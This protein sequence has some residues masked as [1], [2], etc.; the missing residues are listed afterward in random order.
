MKILLTGATGYIGGSVAAKLLETGH[1]VIGLVRSSEAA[2]KVQQQGI[3][4]LIG[5]L[6]DYQVLIDAAHHVDA[7]INTADSDHPFVVT[8]LLSALVGSNK[9]FIHT[10]GS[11]LVGDKAAG[12]L[13]QRIFHEDIAFAPLTEKAGRVAIDQRILTSAH[14]GIRSVVLC[15]SLI[16]GQGHGLKKNSIQI[17]WLIELAKT[18]GVACH[19]GKG[20]NIWSHI[21]IDDVVKLY[22]LA[23][24][25][26][27]PGSFFFVENGEASM[28]SVAEAISRMLGMNGQ[29]CSITIDEAIKAWGPEAAH[30]AFGSNSRVRATKARKLLGWNPTGRALFEEIEQGYYCL[31]QPA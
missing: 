2:A 24:Q 10:S 28:K 17:P 20:E 30:F 12:E 19:I 1:Q 25:H 15:H 26:A 22:L 23:M 27:S 16:Y 8:T 18:R 9:L 5:A 11:S 4:P 13:S 21:H 7:V 31:E 6:S 14:E 29:T 3:E